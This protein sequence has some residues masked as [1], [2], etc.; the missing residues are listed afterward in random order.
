M[1]D[2]VYEVYVDGSCKPSNP[3]PAGCAAIVVINGVMIHGV[4]QFLGEGTNNIAEL[5]AIKCALDLI[6]DDDRKLEKNTIYSDSMYVCNLFNKK[7]KA[8]KNRELVANLRR[9]FEKFPLTTIIW[10]KAHNGNQFNEEADQRAKASVD[11]N[12]RNGSE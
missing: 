4:S 2:D 5:R 10:I 12:I 6:E 8:N 3:G 1:V 11:N 9:R 7:W